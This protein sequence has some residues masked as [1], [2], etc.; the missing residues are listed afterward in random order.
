MT[1]TRTRAALHAVAFV[2]A[3]VCLYSMRRADPD[4]FGYLASGRLFVEQGGLTTQDPFAYTSAGFHWVTFEYGVRT[5]C[6]G[7]PTASRGPSGSSR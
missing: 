7:W 1:S 2:A 5:C 6:C 4:L 3:A